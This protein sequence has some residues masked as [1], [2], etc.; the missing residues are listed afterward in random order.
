MKD[1]TI[2]LAAIAKDEAAYLPE[3]I[4][5][6][7]EFGFD[8]IEIYINNTSDNSLKILDKIVNRLPVKY[9]VVDELYNKS[10]RDF[11]FAAY[12]QLAIEAKTNGFDYVMFLDIDEFWTP[13]D[14]KSSIQDLVAKLNF[15]QAICL[16]WAMHCDEE[17]EFSVCHRDSLK[18]LK[19][20]HVKTLF[21]T[22]A[23]WE[24]I[25]AHNILGEN[26]SYI[27]ANGSSYIFP[28][29]ESDRAKLARSVETYKFCYVLHRAYRS[30]KEY[31][32][33]L[34]RGRPSTTGIKS[35]RFGYYSENATKIV[36]E[37][38][39]E[40]VADHKRRYIEFID[41]FELCHDIGT[42]KEFVDSRYNQV[43]AMIQSAKEKDYT[44]ILRVLKGVKLEEVVR[45]RTELDEKVFLNNYVESN[46]R[47]ASP[48]SLLALFYKWSGNKKRYDS[49]R[50]RLA[51]KQASE[52]DDFVKPSNLKSIL[53]KNGVSPKSVTNVFR[54]LAT[55]H[56]KE[57]KLISSEAY[58]REALVM[59]PNGVYI[60]KL[61]KKIESRKNLL[62]RVTD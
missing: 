53:H 29:E 62:K 5:H 21:R 44:T 51:L 43:L 2:K 12:K 56:L 46:I 42:A 7:L 58:A 54:D 23:P 20:T 9:R 28:P 13:S 14:F 59:R 50:V 24:K 26:I 57:F 31:I 6:H 25:S 27:L 49:M 34:G 11:Q 4:F 48:H 1:I 52:R 33:L 55:E 39:S 47:R 40:R 18:V 19:H 16:Q 45:L 22:S 10:S 3:W 41:S 32:S 61:V 38:P 60:A 17:K 36:L 35:N 37:Y 30:E 8:E 15:P